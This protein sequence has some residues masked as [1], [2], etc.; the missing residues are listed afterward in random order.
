MP[1][2]DMEC[3]PFTALT[4]ARSVFVSRSHALDNAGLLSFAT[5]FWMIP[6]M[7]A[8]FRN[9]LETS[10]LNMSPLDVADVSAKRSL[11]S[12]EPLAECN[13]VYCAF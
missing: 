7:W 9:E 2:L 13:M 10:D 8:V 5:F 12:F 1:F 11:L 4:S 3:F 6:K